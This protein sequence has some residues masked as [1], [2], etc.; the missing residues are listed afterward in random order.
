MHIS[1]SLFP[2]FFL[3]FVG[4]CVGQELEFPLPADATPETA[5]RI[6]SEYEQEIQ[7]FA[8]LLFEID[9]QRFRPKTDSLQSFLEKA[10]QNRN[11]LNSWMSDLHKKMEG[12]IVIFNYV[13]FNNAVAPRLSGREVMVGSDSNLVDTLAQCSS[14]DTILLP[15]GETKIGRRRFNN[16]KLQDIEIRGHANGSIL[17]NEDRLSFRGQDALKRVRFANVDFD[18][19]DSDIDLGRNAS[20]NFVNC[21]FT[22]YN[23]GAGGSNALF[24]V[25][26][27]L[28]IEGCVFDGLRGRAMDI[29]GANAFDFRGN[30]YVYLRNTKFLNN[31]EIARSVDVVIADRCHAGSPA[32]LLH[33]RNSI[34]A[35]IAIV[36]KS[37]LPVRSS[38]EFKHSIDDPA[39]FRFLNSEIKANGK[40]GDV[41]EF[42]DRYEALDLKNNLLYW[43]GMMK[44]NVSDVREAAANRVEQ[45]LGITVDRP[46]KSKSAVD[47]ESKVT[48][49]VAQLDD[50]DHKLREAATEELKLLGQEATE[51]LEAVQ[52]TGSVEQQARIKNI[53]RE[54]TVTLDS[55]F[56][57]ESGRILNWYEQHQEQLTYDADTDSFRKN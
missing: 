48:K 12:P 20:V 32:R 30:D 8:N 47:L 55:V 49:L 15:A 19:K 35:D 24:G 45:L 25:N 4:V 7:A 6:Q 18:C 57:M 36:R 31:D 17:T 33:A 43:I 22:N 38:M 51:F 40:E 56:A 44:S 42:S 29:G 28:L 2:M 54:S 34:S 46:K 52:R 9:R 16:R 13:F 21:K 5:E 53:L 14:G 26:L 11:S 10:N 50:S 27:T 41:A 39:F 37:N 3:F 1:K 23:S